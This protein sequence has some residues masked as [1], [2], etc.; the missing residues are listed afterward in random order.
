MNSLIYILLIIAAVEAVA[1]LVL[2][3]KLVTMYEDFKYRI[4]ME[5]SRNIINEVRNGR[6]NPKDYSR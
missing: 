4:Y 3:F 5:H 1:I 6:G 2:S